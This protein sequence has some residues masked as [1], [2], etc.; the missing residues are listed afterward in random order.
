MDI[1][2]PFPPNLKNQLSICGIRFKAGDHLLVCPKRYSYFLRVHC[3]FVMTD[4]QLL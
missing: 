4:R 2:V 1:I 3:N